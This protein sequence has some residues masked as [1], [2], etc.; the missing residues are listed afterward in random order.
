MCYKTC[1]T[2]YLTSTTPLLLRNSCVC[3]GVPLT[4]MPRHHCSL[5]PRHLDAQVPY[6]MARHV[7][8]RTPEKLLRDVYQTLVGPK[9]L[10]GRRENTVFM[11]AHICPRGLL[12]QTVH[13]AKQLR[14]RHWIQLT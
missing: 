6:G 1:L 11:Q 4:L 7:H 2:T 8:L 5:S 14:R 10:N 3:T 9:A 13:P 12:L